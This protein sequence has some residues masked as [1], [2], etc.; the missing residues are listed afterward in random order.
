[1]LTYNNPTNIGHV[2]IKSTF[3][4]TKKNVTFTFVCC[5]WKNYTRLDYYVFICFKMQFQTNFNFS[6][7]S[8]KHL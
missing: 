5:M 4:A 7:K 6:N 2:G 3:L 8:E 1:M